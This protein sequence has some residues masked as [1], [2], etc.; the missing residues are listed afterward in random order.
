MPL[1]KLHIDLDAIAANWRTAQERHAAP[2][3]AVVKAN[4]Y[5]LGA[6]PVAQRLLREGC[7]SFFTAHLE[8]AI[9]IRKS[10]S[11]RPCRI[12]ALNGLLPR[13]AARYVRHG[14]TPVLGSLAEI[15]AWAAHAKRAETALPAFLHIDTG[16]HR[17]GL[18]GAE[19]T[20]LIAEP[21]RLAGIALAAIMT[22]LT[23][24]DNPKAPANREQLARFNAACAHFPGVKRSLANSGGIFLGPDFRSDLARPGAALYGINPTPHLP[25]P[26]RH[27]ATL[28][29]RVL[30]IRQIEAG[31]AVG[32]G[33]YWRAGRPS[34]I[35]TI[36]AGY[37][38]GWLRAQSNQGFAVFD[39]RALPLVGRISMDLTTYD[40]TD[41]PSL[42]AGDWI[43]L[44]GPSRPVDAV[45]DS[46]GTNAW[47]IL[48]LLGRRYQRS[49]SGA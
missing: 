35:A 13:A 17:L 45:A 12:A 29:A 23:T 7:T 18:S 19:L 16:M 46:A 31:E 28:T 32:Y 41:A 30:Q 38:D 48:A 42:R 25:N 24:A 33:G 39:G 4:G 3:A 9:T 11:G 26:M 40:A 37:A 36:G 8:E 44:I 27:A 14:I 1:A 10:A 6:V 49:Y 5:G 15:A 43:E 21:E 22:H 34:R 2:A 20:R 47:E